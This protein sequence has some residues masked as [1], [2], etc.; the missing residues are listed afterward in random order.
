MLVPDVDA[1]A[2]PDL[3]TPDTLPAKV[4]TCAVLIVTAVVPEPV[5]VLSSSMPVLSAVRANPS[6]AL[7]ALIIVAI[8]N[9]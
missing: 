7:P 6:V 4:T 5:P 1:T 8:I 2:V 3:I 9:L